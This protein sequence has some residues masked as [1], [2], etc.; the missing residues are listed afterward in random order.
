MKIADLSR[1][2]YLI[3]LTLIALF[4]INTATISQSIQ[5]GFSSG[6]ITPEVGKEIPGGFNKNISTG[7]HDPLEVNVIALK[8]DNDLYVIASF[9]ALALPNDLVNEIRAKVAEKV[10]ISPNKIILSATHTHS[11][12]PIVDVFM[13]ERDKDYSAQVVS[14]GVETILEALRNLTPVSIDVNSAEV[15][16]IGFNRRF[17]M[18]DGTVVTHPGKMNPNI[19]APAGP[20]DPQLISLYFTDEIHTPMGIVVNYAL[21]ATVLGGNKFSAD[22]IYYIRNFLRDKWGA[23]L[24]V[25]FLNGACGDV[26]QVNNLSPSPTEFGEDWAKKIGETIATRVYEGYL[27]REPITQPFISFSSNLIDITYRDLAT[28]SHI[29]HSGLGSTQQHIYEREIELLK[30]LQ[31]TNPIIKVELSALRIGD[32]A[33]VTNPTEMFCRLGLD[34][35]KSSPA[36]YTMIA[37][38]TNGYTG[39]CPTPEAFVEGGYEIILARSSCMEQDSALKILQCSRRLLSQ[40]FADSSTPQNK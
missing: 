38:L 2:K 25:V 37:E 33:I 13:S 21:H 24:A 9:D 30:N 6:D 17:Y 29:P 5:A 4:V 8:N 26:T 14:T 10:P 15:N 27:W 22:Y 19:I 7:V 28:T 3:F 35:K 31:S 11:G 23:N 12:G 32:V 39:Y 20:V 40:L 34:I 16:G 36:K 18:K 1:T